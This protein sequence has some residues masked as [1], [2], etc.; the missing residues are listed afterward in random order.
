M[1]VA[2]APAATFTPLTACRDAKGPIAG[3]VVFGGASTL[4]AMKEDG[5]GVQTLFDVP[6]TAIAHQ[7]AW[8]PDGEML[9]QRS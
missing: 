2:P 1:S 7:P 8:S 5:N 3:P 4:L 9:V 6:N